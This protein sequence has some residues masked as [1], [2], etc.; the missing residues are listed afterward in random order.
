MASEVPRHRGRGGTA[1]YTAR[2]GLTRNRAAPAALRRAAAAPDRMS[3]RRIDQN[4]ATDAGRALPCGSGWSRNCQAA[5]SAGSG[6]SGSGAAWVCFESL[7]P[8]TIERDRMMQV[9]RSGEAQH[10]LQEDLARRR[11][12]QVGAADDVR[13]A[14]RGVIDN[15]GQLVREKPV[16]ALD[17]EVAHVTREILRLRALQPVAEIDAG[18]GRDPKGPGF[19]RRARRACAGPP[20]FR[21]GRSPD[22]HARR[23]RPPARSRFRAACTRKGRRRHA[24]ATARARPRRVPVRSDWRTDRSVPCESVS[25]ER[26]ED[27]ALGAAP[28]AGCVDVLDA[29]EPGSARRARVA[30]ARERRDE[31]AEVQRTGGRGGEAA[32]GAGRASR[33]AR[34]HRA[35]TDADTARSVPVRGAYCQ[36]RF[37]TAMTP[38]GYSE[39][40]RLPL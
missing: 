11:C 25:L 23:R 36:L 37:M 6:S 3:R 7:S 12:E 4:S 14:L 5:S 10:S 31:R 15:D 19:A 35:E 26:G 21:R 34:G 9:R 2:R 16:C 18:F 8:R 13:D 32:A 38:V 30:A 33:P 22:R 28:R 17:D 1:N 40:P 20:E 39:R 24:I 29:H 27:R